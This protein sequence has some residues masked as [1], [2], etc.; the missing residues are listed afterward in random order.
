MYNV[1]ILFMYRI[2]KGWYKAGVKEAVYIGLMIICLVAALW[3]AGP[4][5]PPYKGVLQALI[6]KS[7]GVTFF[8]QKYILNTYGVLQDVSH[9][10]SKSIF[11]TPVGCCKATLC[12]TI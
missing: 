3:Y 8:M 6:I 2:I 7:R 12:N 11:V 5:P 9:I 4:I 10:H 1:A